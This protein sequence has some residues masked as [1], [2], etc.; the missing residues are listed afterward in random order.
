MVEEC[1]R[2]PGTLAV[3]V[4]ETQKTL[5]ESAKRLI[6]SKIIEHNVG[7]LFEVFHDRIKSPGMA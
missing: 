7:G 6:E 5:K 3:C 2:T 4:R 1:I